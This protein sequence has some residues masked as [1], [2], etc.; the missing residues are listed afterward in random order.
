MLGKTGRTISSYSPEFHW[1]PYERYEL[2][3][4]VKKTAKKVV[5]YESQ[6]RKNDYSVGE[7]QEALYKKNQAYRQEIERKTG[8]KKENYKFSYEQ[9]KATTY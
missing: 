1:K 5:G 9:V 4:S 7:C 8:A 3:R 2:K 6:H